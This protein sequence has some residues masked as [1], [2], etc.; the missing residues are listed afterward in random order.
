MGIGRERIAEAVD[1]SSAGARDEPFCEGRCLNRGAAEAGQHGRFFDHG[2][3]LGR[4]SIPRIKPAPLEQPLHPRGHP[5]E[6]DADLVVCRRRQGPKIERVPFAASVENAVEEQRVEMDVQV[7][8]F[9]PPPKRWM[10]VEAEEHARGHAEHRARHPVIPGQEIAKTVRQTQH[11]L[12]HGHARQH[13]VDQTGGALGHASAAAARA[14][15]PALAGKRHEVLQRAVGTSQAREAVRQHPAG[16]E[17]PELLFHEPRQRGAVGVTLG[18][19]EEGVEVLGDHA[20][21]HGVLGITRP[22]VRGAGRH[23]GDI[24]SA[25]ERR[26]CPKMDTPQLLGAP[27]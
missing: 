12:A 27:A 9:N 11:P 17:V 5:R 23:G 15:A 6:H 22:V 21:Q 16:Q 1:E 26:Q 4:V 7:Q 24:A 19:L 14:E 20:V 8:S 3:G 10:T 18:R 2:I 25:G 13:L